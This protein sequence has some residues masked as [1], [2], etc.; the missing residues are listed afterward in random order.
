VGVNGYQDDVRAAAA[1]TILSRTSLGLSGIY[2][3]TT[4]IDFERGAKNVTLPASKLGIR[5]TGA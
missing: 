5:S 2:W 4:N 3:V 1:I